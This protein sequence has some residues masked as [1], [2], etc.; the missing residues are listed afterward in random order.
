LWMATAL[1]FI[2]GIYP[3]P[4]IRLVQNAAGSLVALR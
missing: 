4:W 2:I 3:D 1:V